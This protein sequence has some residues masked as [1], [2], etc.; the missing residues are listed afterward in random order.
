MLD[1]RYI[2]E[3]AQA[4]QENARRKGYDVNVE[5]VLRWDKTKRQLQ[6]QAD[7]LRNR[8]NDISSRMKGGKPTDDLIAE[9]KEIKEQLAEV[10]TS[11]KEA[12]E[13]FMAL[14][15]KVPNMALA[16][17]PVGATEDE[18]VVAKKVGEP[19]KFD[20][21]PKNHA[22]LADA[23]GWMD[24]ERAAKVAGSRFTYLKGDMVK[25]QFAIIQFV[26]DK[27][28]DQTFLDEIIRENN[29]NVSNKP[30]LPVLPPFML[31]TDLYDAMDRLEPRD[32]RYKIEGDDLWLQGSA[33]H[34][35]GSM[36]ADEILDEK[37]LPLRYIGYATSFRREAGTYGKDME[38]TFRMHQFDKLEM[39]SLGVAEKGLDE[40]LFM[41]AIQ[42]KLMQ[43]LEIPYQVLLKCTADIGKPNARGVDIEAWLPGQNKYRETHTA[44]YMTDYQARRL[45]TRVRRDSGE[46]ELIH[47]NDATALPLSRGPIAILENHQQAD[48]TVRIPVALRQYIGGREIL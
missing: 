4:V 39:E 23:R 19:T 11:L 17:V 20:F 5:E 41:V 21:E 46:V 2:R 29:L 32:D 14:L 38:G 13:N 45:K 48:G 12:D 44:D 16:D 18:N 22:V 8:R 34:V 43:L 33:E 3:N 37:D 15:K 36:H 40:H 7:E 28:S 10:E 6:Q 25:L 30:F 27:L 9:G 31:R 26:M 42:E 24:K 35:L 47:T 1:I